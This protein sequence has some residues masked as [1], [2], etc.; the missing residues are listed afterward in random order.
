MRGRTHLTAVAACVATHQDECVWTGGGASEASH[1]TD[2][3]AGR[4]QQV[5][6]AVSEKVKGLEP[7]DLT[8]IA[9]VKIDFP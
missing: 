1:V 6:G 9:P 3:V 8:A 5:E 7:S 2:G 4:V